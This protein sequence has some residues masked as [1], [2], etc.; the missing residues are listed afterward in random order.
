MYEELN[1]DM[2][3][4]TGKEGGNPVL[5][6]NFVASIEPI[7]TKVRN[8]APQCVVQFTSGAV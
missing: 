3:T 2:L 1:V 8:A 6:V 4:F 7:N 5:P